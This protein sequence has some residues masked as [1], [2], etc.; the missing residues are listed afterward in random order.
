MLINILLRDIHE[1]HLL[2]DNDD[3]QINFAAKLNTLD[4]GKKII[5]NIYF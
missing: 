3:E 1:V 5:K 4:K 2:T